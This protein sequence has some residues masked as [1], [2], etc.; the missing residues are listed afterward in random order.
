[1][2]SKTLSFSS[3][4]KLSVR[5]QQLVYDG[6][7]DV[8]RSFPIE[9]IGVVIIETDMVT[10][11]SAAIRELSEANVA[12][13]FCDKSHM[14]ESQVL[15]YASNVTTQE[16]ASA[17]LAATDAVKGRIWKQVIKSKIKNQ[18]TLLRALVPGAGR[19][20]DTLENDVKNGDPANCEAQA[21]RIYFQNITR[22]DDFLRDPN[23]G[24]PNSALNYGYAIL[25]AAT[26]RAIVGSGLLCFCGIHH[27][28]RYNAYCLADD[29]MEP[30]RPFVD[31][32]VFGKIPPFDVSSEELTKEMRHK[33]LE[34]LTCDVVTCDVKRPLSIALTFTTASLAK[35]FLGKT[36]K[37]ILPEFTDDLHSNGT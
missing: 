29:L 17:Q 11:T 16:T 2:I 20:L 4:G 10:I 25:R 8:H 5:Y 30:Y 21:A 37:L 7:D 26:A 31:Q 18:K 33:L 13:I 6:G 22:N 3:A 27:H 23:G 28:N 34:V 15:P 14:P 24:W 35:Y 19:R 32:Y 36:D 9:D 12:L 1:M